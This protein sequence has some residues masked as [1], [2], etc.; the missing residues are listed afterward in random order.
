MHHIHVYEGVTI[1][2]LIHYIG[3]CRKN[4]YKVYD[5]ERHTI[6]AYCTCYYTLTLKL[7]EMDSQVLSPKTNFV[8]HVHKLVAKV[9][10]MYMH[11]HNMYNGSD[12]P[13]FP[14]TLATLASGSIL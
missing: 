4:N 11:I 14:Y 8:E 3:I 6:A 12:Y 2:S 7:T 9:K 13:E 10:V 1:V 5:S